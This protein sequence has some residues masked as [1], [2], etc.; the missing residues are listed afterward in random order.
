M[1]AVRHL[2]EIKDAAPCH[3][4]TT[5]KRPWHPPGVGDT[6]QTYH[7][8][9]NARGGTMSEIAYYPEIECQATPSELQNTQVVT[10][11]DVSGASQYLR[12]ATGFLTEAGHKTY[13]PVRVIS[14]ERNPLRVL[15][16]LP[17][18]ADSGTSRVWVAAS[19]FRR[20]ETSADQPAEAI[21]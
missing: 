3:H 1:T 16:E 4:N 15:V 11:K 9:W 14:F 18:E 12:V 10:V 2:R 7:N 8:Q 13:L 6:V 17:Y 19:Q 20:A 21:A 5:S